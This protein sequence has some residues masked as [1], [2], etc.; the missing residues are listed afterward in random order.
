MMAYSPASGLDRPVFDHTGLSG[1][2]DMSFEW[3]ARPNSVTGPSPPGFTPDDTGPTFF[4]A[5]QEQLGLKLVPKTGPVDVLV[6]DR[7][8]QPSAN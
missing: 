1:T 2:F 7:V 4:E 8:K 5:L 6:I 3:T